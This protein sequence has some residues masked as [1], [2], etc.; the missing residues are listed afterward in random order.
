VTYDV[1]FC[2]AVAQRPVSGTPEVRPKPGPERG[3]G[4]SRKD[5]SRHRPIGAVGL[6]STRG[7]LKKRIFSYVCDVRS[8][9]L[10]SRPARDSE[11]RCSLD[12]SLPGRAWLVTAGFGALGTMKSFAREEN[13]VRCAQLLPASGG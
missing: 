7:A 1:E 2:A 13:T 4:K 8:R 6:D 10:L 5:W 9:Q 11:T 3:I 12:D